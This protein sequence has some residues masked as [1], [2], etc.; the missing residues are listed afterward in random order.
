MRRL[1]LVL[2]TVIAFA[3]AGFAQKSSSGSTTAVPSA[4]PSGSQ[5]NTTT[6]ATTAPATTGTQTPLA[7]G[8]TSTVNP[9]TPE[10]PTGGSPMVPGSSVPT[11]TSN[12]QLNNA[13]TGNGVVS[14][15]AGGQVVQSFHL[16]T[17]PDGT[18]VAVPNAP[19][20]GSPILPST[21]PVVSSGEAAAPVSTD[22]SG[23]VYVSGNLPQQQVDSRSLGEIAAQYKR[24]RSV[25]AAHVY[26]NEDIDRLN[27]RNDVNVM[28]PNQNAAL[29][30]GEGAPAQQPAVKKSQK[31]SPF[32]PQRPQ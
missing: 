24:N 3:C 30:Q 9:G 12:Q 26:T 28:G 17:Q 22:M 25:Q 5:V 16:D 31:R 11:A 15:G 27:A 21:A 10:A 1:S 6:P 14:V 8:T 19:G 2:L 7:P 23:M 18:E 32:T 20:S 4:P 29:P 13:T